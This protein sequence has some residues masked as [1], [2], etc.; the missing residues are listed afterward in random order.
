MKN[1]F[2]WGNYDYDK[3][4]GLNQ[5]IKEKIEKDEREKFLQNLKNFN[6]NNNN[7]ES[8]NNNN[9]NNQNINNNNKND[10]IQNLENINNIENNKIKNSNILIN[11]GET[12]FSA[13]ISTFVIKVIGKETVYFFKVDCFSEI[14]GKTW[15][16]Y[17]KYQ[18]FIDLSFLFYIYFINCPINLKNIKLT[19]S[20]IEKIITSL[21]YFLI[22]IINRPDLFTN[23]YTQNF[24]RLKNH[25][26]D[27]N[28]YHPLEIYNLNNNNKNNV[29]EINFPI[30]NL[31]YCELTKLLFVGTGNIINKT[32]VNN[33]N[34][35]TKK[36][37]SKVKNKINGLFQTQTLNNNFNEI[38]GELIIY[39]IINTYNKSETLFIKL[40]KYCFRNSVSS[41]DY[42]YG[43]NYLCI[44]LENGEIYIFKVYIT[45]SSSESKNFC[46]CI[47]TLNNIHYNKILSVIIN[48]DLGYIYSFAKN[49]K[50]FKISDLNCEKIIKEINII[51]SGIEI[52]N[53]FISFERILIIDNEGNLYVIDIL[54][55]SLNPKIL[56]IIHKNFKEYCIMKIFNINN[57]Y[58]MFFSD[59][60]SNIN[61]YYIEDINIIKINQNE[62][63]LIENKNVIINDIL[64]T[65]KNEILFAFSNGSINVYLFDLNVPI[66]VLDNHLKNCTKILYDHNKR[67][68]FSG[69]EDKCIKMSQLPLEWSYNL[70]KKNKDNYEYNY[71][72]NM[73]N[74]MYENNL[75]Y[76]NKNRNNNYKDIYKGNKYYT[77]KEIF[78]E[79]LDGW[80]LN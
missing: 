18:D 44:G 41:M 49:E 21:N 11:S 30:T 43:K 50:I 4:P 55:D 62:I 46:D 2:L 8:N 66:Y 65:N 22:F 79:D 58:I 12:Q 45:E 67:I 76:N 80:D 47:I 72:I 61:I 5:K 74:Y 16:V 78:S 69:G 70:I 17:H 35:K 56:Q 53:Y 38:N 64:I 42:F 54:T 77:D 9:N 48:F 24:L 57:L 71:I 29:N 23:K 60:K 7:I 19:K 15:F 37:Y 63:K 52:V 34:E 73:I 25:Y 28:L 27:I 40:F 51:K 26:N 14:T 39:N 13:N 20:N 36:I 33:I 31:F 3:I 68:L 6:E 59:I 75:I 10:N 32:I 1:Q